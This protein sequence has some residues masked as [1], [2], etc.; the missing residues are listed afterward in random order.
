MHFAAT[1]RELTSAEGASVQVCYATHS[2]YFV[3]P[4]DVAS[5]WICRRAEHPDGESASPTTIT[6]ADVSKVSAL[7]PDGDQTKVHRRLSSTLRASFRETFFARAVL[8]V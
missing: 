8:L 6:A 7:L 4:S 2:P 5:I 1:L 3:T